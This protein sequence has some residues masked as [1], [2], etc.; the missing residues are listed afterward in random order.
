MLKK[1]RTM[2]TIELEQVHQQLTELIERAARGEDI[3][4][5]KDQMP[6]VKL[7]SVKPGQRQRRL[8]TAKGQIVMADD[9]DAPLEDF[10][11]YM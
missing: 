8:D 9:F 2:Q 11:E 3:I 6:I 7:I 4:I 10:E 5:T 1:E